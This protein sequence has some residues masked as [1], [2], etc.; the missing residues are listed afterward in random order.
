ME[1]E[2]RR[3]PDHNLPSVSQNQPAANITIEPRAH[4]RAKQV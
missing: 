2:R 3:P 1:I 4:N